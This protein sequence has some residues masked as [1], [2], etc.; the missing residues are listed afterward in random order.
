MAVPKYHS[1]W[2]VYKSLRL[3]ESEV[4][5]ELLDL[6]LRSR[7]TPPPQNGTYHSLTHFHCLAQVAGSCKRGVQ[8][9]HTLTDVC[10]GQA[11]AQQKAQSVKLRSACWRAVRTALPLWRWKFPPSAWVPPE[12]IS[13]LDLIGSS[14]SSLFRKQALKDQEFSLEK[15][16]MAEVQLKISVLPF[17]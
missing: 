3:V 6:V 12:I 14:R 2:Q 17:D 15:T 13:I 4:N 1:Y 8:A 7:E 9:T 5:F 16:A 11:A 10:V